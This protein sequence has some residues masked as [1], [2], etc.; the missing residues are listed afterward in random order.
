[1][2]G[3]SCDNRERRDGLSAARLWILVLALGFLLAWLLLALAA[4]PAGAAPGD[5]VWQRTVL[6]AGIDEVG[7]VVMARQGDI[8][9]ACTGYEGLAEW[10][11]DSDVVVARYRLDGTRRWARVFDTRAHESQKVTGIAVDRRGCALVTGYVEASGGVSGWWTVKVSPSGKKLWAARISAE[12]VSGQGSGVAV[13]ADGNVYVAGQLPARTGPTTDAAVVKYSPAGTW[14]W[15][16]RLDGGT[17]PIGGLGDVAVDARGRVFVAGN[18]YRESGRVST[19]MARYSR[20]GKRIWRKVWREEGARS[21]A[22]SDLEV[23]SAGVAAAGESGEPD[24]G[25]GLLLRRR[26]RDGAAQVTLS[27]DGRDLQWKTLAMNDAGDVGLAG[28]TTSDGGVHI[29]YVH[30]RRPA[31]GPAEAPRTVSGTGNQ[32]YPYDVAISR[33]GVVVSTGFARN[34]ASGFDLVVLYDQPSAA[35]WYRLEPEPGD[36]VGTAV[37]LSAT[38]VIVGGYDGYRLSLWRFKR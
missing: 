23:T 15:A 25:R 37:V 24:E 26:I 32:A 10:A 21:S 12:R 30:W 9:L 28:T 7:D 19:V 13:D 8:W 5:E 3:V 6:P 11:V 35:D 27:A 22:L 33:G 20:E 29:D 2:Y 34:D 16:R 17:Y 36:Q 31:A 18:L 38:A 14:R 1:M 4:E